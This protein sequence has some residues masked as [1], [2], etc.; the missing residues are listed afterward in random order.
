MT[1]VL[2]QTAATVTSSSSISKELLGSCRL[3]ELRPNI[4]LKVE[5]VGWS[6]SRNSASTSFKFSLKLMSHL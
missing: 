1:T 5:V 3:L 2:D 4:P 6:R